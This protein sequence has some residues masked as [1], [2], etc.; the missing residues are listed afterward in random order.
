MIL[1]V[2]L[3]K[4]SVLIS[5]I[6]IFKTLKDSKKITGRFVQVI[7][8]LPHMMGEENHNLYCVCFS[9]FCQISTVAIVTISIHFIDLYYHDFVKVLYYLNRKLVDAKRWKDQ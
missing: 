4:F 7:I 6:R 1:D 9:K 3:G 8:F 5:R 2:N